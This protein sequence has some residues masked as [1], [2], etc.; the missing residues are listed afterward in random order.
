MEGN[1]N[2]YL[3]TQPPIPR[4][5]F[6]GTA[7][8]AM[9]LVTPVVQLALGRISL[10]AYAWRQAAALV[11]AYAVFGAIYIFDTHDRLTFSNLAYGLYRA[12]PPTLGNH[13]I[14]YWKKAAEYR[15]ANLP[16]DGTRFDQ[17]RWRAALVRGDYFVH[18]ERNHGYMVTLEEVFRTGTVSKF[19]REG[20]DP[21]LLP[22]LG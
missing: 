6:T 4:Q 22:G 8:V 11:G 12:D 1:L 17:Q 10:A 20:G 3:T 13:Y 21:P 9:G 14:Q 7:V 5:A 2:P 18:V 15:F 16:K 19:I